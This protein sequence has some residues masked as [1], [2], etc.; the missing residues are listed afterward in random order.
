MAVDRH[1]LNHCY[2][3]FLAR[4][5]VLVDIEVV[6]DFVAAVFVGSLA[7]DFLSDYCRIVEGAFDRIIILARIAYEHISVK[8]AV[9]VDRGALYAVFT[10][11]EFLDSGSHLAVG[12]IPLDF[13]V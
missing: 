13:L 3:D 10:F 8:D 11:G 7:Y 6:G 12:A 1:G 2:G 4:I 9:V 5:A